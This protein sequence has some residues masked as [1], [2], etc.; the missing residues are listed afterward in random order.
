MSWG[1]TQPP[2]GGRRAGPY[3]LVEGWARAL[4]PSLPTV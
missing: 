4:S 1:E 2:R 3:G